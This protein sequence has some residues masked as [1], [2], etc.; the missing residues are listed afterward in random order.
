[1]ITI[2]PQNRSISFILARKR[3]FVF[4][5]NFTGSQAA[6]PFVTFSSFYVFFCLS[7]WPSCS[8]SDFSPLSHLRIRPLSWPGAR[9]LSWLPPRHG[10]EM[11]L[12]FRPCSWRSEHG[13]VFQIT[14]QKVQ[15]HGVRYNHQ[16]EE[17]KEIVYGVL[18]IE[19]RKLIIWRKP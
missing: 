7:A 19:G 15:V 9:F 5:S 11:T 1:M 2:W 12:S 14:G 16:L 8:S 17:F 10:V 13:F 4:V 18:L 3:V 6:I